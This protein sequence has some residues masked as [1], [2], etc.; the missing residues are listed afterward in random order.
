MTKIKYLD[1]SVQDVMAWAKSQVKDPDRGYKGLCQS[2]CRSAYGVPAW[3]P[4]A[5]L[6]W[7]KIPAKH[8]HAGG[9]PSDAPRGSLL[10]YSG[11][12]Y[13]HV[14]IAAGRK[15][16]DKCLSNDY[17]R[18]EGG[19]DYAPRTFPRWGIKYLGWSAWTPFGE[20]DVSS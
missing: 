13:G 16:S 11:G 17:V 19:I 15:T 18:R 6:A 1:R 14:A 12:K 3:A 20:L 8:K 2:F 5:I 7:E 4:S 10:Y 9:S